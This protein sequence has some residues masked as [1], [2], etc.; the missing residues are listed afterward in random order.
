MLKIIH[1]AITLRAVKF[2]LLQFVIQNVSTL[3]NAE[4][5]GRMKIVGK[6]I[7]SI[8]RI[9]IVGLP[10]LPSLLPVLQWFSEFRA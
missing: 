10:L 5:Q 2:E 1:S 4:N 9:F 6:S 8:T 3:S 7:M